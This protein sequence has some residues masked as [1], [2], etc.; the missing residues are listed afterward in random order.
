MDPGGSVYP[1]GST[2]DPTCLALS[3]PV[4]LCHPYMRIVVATA[5]TANLSFQEL[6]ELLPAMAIERTF[7]Q[8]DGNGVRRKLSVQG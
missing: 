1:R 8:G 3:L 6:L 4:A 2:E 5:M 7:C